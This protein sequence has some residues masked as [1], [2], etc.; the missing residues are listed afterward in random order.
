MLES[1]ISD[2]PVPYEQALESM[3]SR[4]DNILKNTSS[5]LI[6]F[7]EH[8][9]IY[10]AG[11]TAVKEDLSNPNKLPVYKTNR[12]GQ[13]TYHG[14]GQLIVYIMINIRR[15]NLCIRE[16]VKLLQ[17]V[18]IETLEDIGIH[19]FKNEYIGVWVHKNN[20]P[21]KISAIGIKMRKYV[22]FHGISINVSPDLNNY[23]G[24]IPCGIKEYGVT[25][26]EDLGKNITISEYISLIKPKLIRDFS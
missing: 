25:S 15:L 23:S 21:H 9:P 7:L 24:I 11:I 10:T 4:V 12:G 1:Y 3:E 16:Y 8:P 5:E 19:A 14:P 13:F 18:V 2:I 26:I 17:D 6:W 22:A 20:I